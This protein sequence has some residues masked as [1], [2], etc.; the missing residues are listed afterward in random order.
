M[1]ASERSRMSLAHR[2][3]ISLTAGVV[4]FGI[5]AYVAY[6]Q[7]LAGSDI[8]AKS[9]RTLLDIGRVAQAIATYRQEAH[10]LP[11]A[12]SDLHETD[13]R[14]DGDGQPVDGWLRP[15]HYRVDGNRYRVISYGRDNRPGGVG[16]DYDLSND[17]LKRSGAAQDSSTRLPRLARPTSGQFRSD[18]TTRVNQLPGCIVF[19][20][21][22]LS[23]VVAFL[24][25][26]GSLRGPCPGGGGLRPRLCGVIATIIGTLL[27]AVFYVTVLANGH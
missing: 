7:Y 4:V 24:L 12:L 3:A 11:G 1:T 10:G 21:S 14:V 26:F 19:A 16:L 13:V 6:N 22:V 8:Q 20:G 2:L 23:G 25:G 18:Q 5:S 17:D 27:V 9:E 15:L